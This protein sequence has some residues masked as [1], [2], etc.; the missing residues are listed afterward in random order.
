MTLSQAPGTFVSQKPIK[1]TGST[2]G[3]DFANVFYYR[4]DF[5]FRSDYLSAA[6]SLPYP[7]YMCTPADGRKQVISQIRNHRF[8]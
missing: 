1:T 8:P 7:D 2:G 6:I 4:C 3:L 5:V